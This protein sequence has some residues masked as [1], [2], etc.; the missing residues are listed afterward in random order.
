MIKRKKIGITVTVAIAL[1]AII[2]TVTILS[3][4]NQAPR[5]VLA[6]DVSGKIYAAYALDEGAV[7]S[8]TF[9][10]SV[11]QSD[12]TEIYEIRGSKIYAVGARYSAFGAGMPADLAPGQTLTYDADGTM[13]LSD[14]DIPVPRLCYVVGTV[15]D[16]Y[17]QIGGDLISLTDLCGRNTAVLFK[18]EE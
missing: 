9:R 8:V 11:N 2:A 17:L 5:L 14:I 10:H 15:Y 4:G 18:Y 7:F 12:V 16:H 6:D 13:V 1:V 3:V